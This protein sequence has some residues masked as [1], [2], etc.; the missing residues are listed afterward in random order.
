[1]AW[2]LLR[3]HRGSAEGASREHR[4]STREHRG[5]TREHRRSTR[6]TPREHEKVFSSQEPKQAGSQNW[7]GAKIDREQ[8]LAA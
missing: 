1:M 3:E 2:P 7:S 5:S 6:K 8:I 4:G